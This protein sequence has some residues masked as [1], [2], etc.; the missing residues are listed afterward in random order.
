MRPG[1][2]E[3]AVGLL[4][5]T[6]AVAAVLPVGRLELDPVVYGLLVEGVMLRIRRHTGVRRARSDTGHT[7]GRSIGTPVN[8]LW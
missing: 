2:P 8:H 1:R 3:I 7:Y 6:A 4:A 5:L